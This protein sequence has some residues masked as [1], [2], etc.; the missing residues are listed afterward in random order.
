M[1]KQEIQADAIIEKISRGMGVEIRND[2]GDRAFYRPLEDCIHLPEKEYFDSDYSYN[3]VAM[4]ELSHATGAAHRLNR[5]MHNTFASQAYAYEELVAEISAVFMSENLTSVCDGYRMENHKAYVQAWAEELERNPDILIKAVKDAESAADYL[6][7][8]AGLVT[9]QEYRRL[10]AGRVEPEMERAG[11]ETRSYSEIR[12]DVRQAGFS[13]S[14]RIVA[15]IERLDRISG[16]ENRMKDICN[17]YRN[18]CA[19]LSGEERELVQA[20]AGECR[21]QQ[22]ARMA[23]VR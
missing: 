19:G 12:S 22:L 21:T 15:G 16:R 9:E 23:P 18:D 3:S 17:A 13:P 4:H 7:Y 11:T 2:G 1:E 14:D 5:P 8:K 6:E 10:N 20:I